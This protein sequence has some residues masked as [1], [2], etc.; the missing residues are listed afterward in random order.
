MKEMNSVT[1]NLGITIYDTLYLEISLLVLD[2]LIFYI[3]AS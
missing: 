1:E 3:N 2:R